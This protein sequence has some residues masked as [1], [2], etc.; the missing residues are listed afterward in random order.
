MDNS[1]I[2]SLRLVRDTNQD[3]LN[4]FNESYIGELEQVQSLK[5]EEFELKAKIDQLQKTLDVYSFK[6]STGH[7]VFSPFA[8]SS[9][10]Q[11]DKATQIE[12]QLAELQEIQNNLSEQIKSRE[13]QIDLLKKRIT[14]LSISNRHLDEL[15]SEVSDEIQ[16]LWELS[17]DGEKSD[18]DTEKPI[19]HGINI[20]RI[21]QHEKKVFADKIQEDVT[22]VLDANFHK[23]EVLSW[24]MRSDVNRAKVTLEEITSSTSKLA[25]HVDE[26]ATTLLN[27]IDSEE[28]LWTLLENLIQGYKDEHPDCKISSDIECADYDIDIPDIVAT[29]L[30]LIIQEIMNNIYTHSNANKVVIKIFI[31]NRLVDVFI[32]DNGVGIDS[33]YSDNSPWYSGLHKV[34][35]II[36]LLN[37]TFKIDGDII[38]GTNVR[39]TFPLV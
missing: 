28:P 36:Y 13:N 35:E 9:S 39:F 3:L 38:S 17:S 37:G 25:D 26:L 10:S 30:V 6:N 2:E 11:Q 29:Q 20:L 7:N 5:T 16:A 19:N 15:L 22:D 4:Y 18:E 21:Q 27:E 32:N 8:T 14:S 1:S 33:N 31:S 23:L 12:N 24:L 34:K